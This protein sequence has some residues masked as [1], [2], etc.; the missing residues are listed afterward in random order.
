MNPDFIIR[1]ESEL[2]ALFGSP[3]ESVI[4]KVVSKLDKAMSDFISRSPLVFV[5]S[6]DQAGLIDVSPKGDAPGFVKIDE[7]G[8]LLIPE[9]PGN[10]LMFGFRNLLR[11]QRIGLI[12]VIPDTRETLRIKGTATLSRDP[13]MLERLSAS[14][15]PALLTTH[16]DI[17]E[18]FFHCGK[19]MIRSRLWQPESWKD[20]ELEMV[21]H[22]AD[23]HDLSE[24]EIESGLEQ[25]YRDKL[26]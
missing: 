15:K 12:F 4:Q 22:F 18:C 13:Q 24:Q 23:K 21:K 9:R 7:G 8:S 19:A 25:S 5:A 16:V 3:K 2:E 26:Y 14:G 1:D 11:D 6:C 20:D 17:D 10:K